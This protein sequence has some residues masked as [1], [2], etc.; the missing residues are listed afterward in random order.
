MKTIAELFTEAWNKKE[1]RKWN[2]VY[3][4]VDL[5]GVILPS[6]YH[7]DNELTFINPH[8]ENVLRYLSQQSDVVLILWTSSYL[9]EIL[10]VTGWLIS[11]GINIKFINKNPDEPNTGY[12]DFSSKP[13]FS[14]LLDDKA[15]FDP[16]TDWDSLNTWIKTREIDKMR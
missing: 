7:S 11:R 15:G 16:H 9:K 3:I 13:Y 14:I 5:H 6:N 4:M 10:R 8:A 12:A 1:S 2:F